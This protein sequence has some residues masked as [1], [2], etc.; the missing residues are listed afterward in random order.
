VNIRDLTAKMSLAEAITAINSSRVSPQLMALI[1]KL[2]KEELDKESAQAAIDRL[3]KMVLDAH[4]QLVKKH[5]ECREF[6]RKNRGTWAQV[7]TDIS[8]FDNQVN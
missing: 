7:T 5:I 6:K 3:N 4:G 1:R 2:G 8:R